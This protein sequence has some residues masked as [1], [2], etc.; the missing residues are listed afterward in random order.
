MIALTVGNFEGFHRGHLKIIKTLI[1]ESRKRGLFSSV[2]TFKKHPMTVIFGIEPEKLIAPSEKIEFFQKEG[3]DLLFNIDFSREFSETMPLDFLRNLKEVL[4]PKLY[5]L[6][7]SF[8]FGKHNLGDIELIKKSASVFNYE[9][10]SVKDMLLYDLP[11]SSTRIR[12]AIK[13][14]QFV[15]VEK[16]LGR[17][18][19]VYLEP[20]QGVK[21]GLRSFISNTALPD[22]GRFSGEIVDLIARKKKR[23]IVNVSNSIFLNS[24]RNSVKDDTLYK[25]YFERSIEEEK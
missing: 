22:Y 3:I 5:C 25:Y 2:I 4:S 11:I 21:G 7:S 10:V 12:S 18:Y 17:R 8:R 19:G 14:G 24:Y 20:D 1:A 23:E 16:L 9:L 6:G 15:L 13:E